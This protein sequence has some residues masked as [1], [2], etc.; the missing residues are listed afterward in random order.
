MSAFT[1]NITLLHCGGGKCQW[2]LI[3]AGCRR[4]S[5]PGELGYAA[6]YLAYVAE[7][8]RGSESLFERHISVRTSL[9]DLESRLLYFGMVYYLYVFLIC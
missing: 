4:L 6:F 5:A 2:L 8:Y 7:W 9:M 1:L 3:N